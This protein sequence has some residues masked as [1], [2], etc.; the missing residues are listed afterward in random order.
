MG[1]KTIQVPKY[2]LHKAACVCRCRM[3]SVDSLSIYL[4]CHCVYL[5]TGSIVAAI[6]FCIIALGWH[7]YD[8]KGTRES[9]PLTPPFAAF[10]WRGRLL[11]YPG[12][13]PY[14]FDS[15]DRIGCDAG[16]GVGGLSQARVR[17]LQM[18]DRKGWRVGGRC[19]GGRCGS[20]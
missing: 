10:V 2:Y 7:R 17:G 20:L 6:L 18:W 15:C 13:R 3:L 4:L 5:S 1:W 9:T 14:G 12:G 8:K 19:G 16:V 11:S